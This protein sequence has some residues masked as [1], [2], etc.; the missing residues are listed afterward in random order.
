MNKRLSKYAHSHEQYTV[1]ELDSK[2]FSSRTTNKDGR[3]VWYIVCGRSSPTCMNDEPRPQITLWWKQFCTLA[4]NVFHLVDP[5]FT[6]LMAV[7]WK[8]CS[9][10]VILGKDDS[11]HESI[12]RLKSEK[13][14]FS[15]D[16]LCLISGW[17]RTHSVVYTEDKH[18]RRSVISMLCA[19][20]SQ[21]VFLPHHR[22]V[23]ACCSLTRESLFIPTDTPRP[24]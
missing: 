18:W 20:E 2:D 8:L 23:S 19:G 11:T 1:T 7:Y 4:G 15:L 6:G 24:T 13:L 10:A 12:C 16:T 21:I 17:E 5:I 22:C 9:A 14:L 3:V